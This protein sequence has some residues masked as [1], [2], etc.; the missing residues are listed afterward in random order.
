[1]SV[2]ARLGVRA[3]HW[4]VVYVLLALFN[5][6][7]VVSGLLLTHR[8]TA[9]F[10][11]SVA[12]NKA[13]NQRLLAYSK[14]GQLASEVNAPGNDIF[15]DEIVTGDAL[16]AAE[17]TLD[18]ALIAFTKALDAA[19]QDARTTLDE[20]ERSTILDDLRAID[21]ANDLMVAEARLVFESLL[22][23]EPA[24]AARHMAAMDRRYAGVY[25]SIARL[26]EHAIASANARLDQ[27]QQA[28]EAV[29]R[30]EAVIAVA[31]LV[32][33]A[34][35]ATYGYKMA[36]RNKAE[37]LERE[38]LL[39]KVRESEAVLEQRIVERTETLAETARRLADAQ[40]MAR[41]GSWEFDLATQVVSWSDE[42]FRLYGFQ[43]GE[44]EPTYERYLEL[45]HPDDR[46]VSQ[47]GVVR[48]LETG[49][50]MARD[51]RIV[52]RDGVVRLFH[53]VGEVVK[54]ASGRPVRLVGSA[55]DVTDARAAQ[56]A[57]RRSEERFQLASKATNDALW[58]W[59]VAAGTVWWNEGFERLTGY[60]GAPSV[61]FWLS[62]VHPDDA[63]R[64]GA[65][66]HL[67][68]GSREESW[69][70]EYR[71]KRA[72]GSYAWVLDR[73]FAIRADDGRCVRMIGSMMDITERKQAESMKS[74]FVSFVSH[75]LRTPLS[76]M[77]WMLEL[78]AEARGMPDDARAHIADARESA[79]RL[80]TL[81]NDLLD[82]A[83][84]ESGRLSAVPE[85]LA[86]SDLTASVV[87]EMQ[88]LAADKSLAMDVSCEAR[89]SPVFADS[90][91]LR[92]VVTNLLSNAV[93]YTPP[94][95]R[96]A[97][98]VAQQN[99]SVT[100]T[101]RDSGVGVPKHAQARLF[102][103]F[104]RADNAI[105]VDAEGT[106]LGLHLVRLIVEQAGGRVWCES[107]EG[108][109]ATFAFTLPAMAAEKE[110]T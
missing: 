60:R 98:S 95:G 7:A 90:Q 57:L 26:R 50:P 79:A 5:V 89:V 73:G 96:I 8:Q 82:I 33:V 30:Y 43:P 24:L 42:L 56:A 63:A 46:A 55:Q 62:L 52:R 81:V 83:K 23:A 101:V 107:D 85:S 99:G 64:V 88:P 12:V 28:A 59:D 110:G 92:Q 91:M 100:W 67:F 40:R 76:G 4:Q 77:S 65:S 75:Q 19:V 69:S 41:I 37:S 74:D 84:L 27:Q 34:A 108:Q 44:V 109:G 70:A 18:A 97:V 49:E 35:A 31:I 106:G 21:R 45:V 2:A 53:A 103:K 68:F 93:K 38:T 104:Y 66:L 86:L 25:D 61:E 14:V 105:S 48:T 9:L 80:S 17:Q 54:D 87:S 29:E 71:F 78:A 10:D 36:R 3:D 72:D 6:L 11:D 39:A 51:E 16:A 1:M 94:G 13:W 20:P 22:R 15:G 58:D 32:M 47:A 102:E